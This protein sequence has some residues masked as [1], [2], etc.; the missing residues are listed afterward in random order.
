[1]CMA[2]TVTLNLHSTDC[3]R[4]YQL[5]YITVVFIQIRW[6]GEFIKAQV[7]LSGVEGPASVQ[8]GSDKVLPFQKLIVWKI[9]PPPTPAVSPLNR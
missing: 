7:V 5:F 6:W 2:D 3:A 8:R 1:M 4:N 9:E